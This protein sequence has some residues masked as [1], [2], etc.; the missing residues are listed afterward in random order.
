LGHTAF[1]YN[2]LAMAIFV[3]KYKN[4]ALALDNAKYKIKA[5]WLKKLKGDL[6]ILRGTPAE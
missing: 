5:T 1:Q 2:K 3:E 6:R 4:R